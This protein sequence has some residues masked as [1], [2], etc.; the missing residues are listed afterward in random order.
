[1]VYDHDLY[2]KYMYGL[3]NSVNPEGDILYNLRLI[4]PLERAYDEVN[5]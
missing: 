3:N 2:C 4:G 5:I 1:M